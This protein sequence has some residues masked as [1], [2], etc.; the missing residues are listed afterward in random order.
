MHLTSDTV[1]HNHVV[2]LKCVRKNLK[3]C[4]RKNHNG[5]F[6]VTP[7]NPRKNLNKA[8]NYEGRFESKILKVGNYKIMTFLFVLFKVLHKTHLSQER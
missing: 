8:N 1:P 7:D 6:K 4:V 3:T 5:V 2:N